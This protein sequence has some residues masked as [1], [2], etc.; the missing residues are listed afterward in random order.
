MK[1]LFLT[2]WY[3]S[4]KDAMSGLF[5][6]KHVEAVRAQGIEVRVIHSQGWSDTWQQWK[7]L[8]REGWMPD[9]VQLNVIQKQGLLALWLK[10]RYG[11]PYVII[12]HWSGYLPENGQFLRMPAF[13]RRLYALIAEKAATLMTVSERHAQA[14]RACG[15]K[16][17][18][19]IKTRNV[20]DD[21]FFQKTPNTQNNQNTQNTPKTLLH[22]SCFD[23]RA[24]NVKGLLRAAQ[25]LSGQRQDWRLVLVGTG[26]DY[27]EVRAYAE[28]LT[29]PAE[30]VEWTGELTPQEVAQAFDKADIFVLNSNYENAP[31]V[32]SESL[33]KGVPVVSTN[34]G[35][36]PEMV[37]EQCG[38]LVPPGDES[39]LTEALNT[40]LDHCHEYDRGTIRQY[41]AQ[42]SFA[43]VGAQFKHV[44]EQILTL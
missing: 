14:M 35:G 15:M 7:A 22:I 9:A 30:R 18:R 11:I 17:A 1:V 44:Y 19:W 5:V 2:P 36:I 33:A 28:T 27:A 16:N 37:N 25:E 43:E 32:I 40:M 20:V 41:G 26:V 34:V 42:Y 12:E 39:R 31:V 13:K 23:E 4:E 29:L 3:P 21:F 38:I 6:Q 8:R 10:K 24:K